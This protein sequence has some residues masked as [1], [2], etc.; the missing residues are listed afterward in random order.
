MDQIKVGKI[1]VLI[2]MQSLSGK[3]RCTAFLT[4]STQDTV[5]IFSASFVIKKHEVVI[6]YMA[7]YNKSWFSEKGCKVWIKIQ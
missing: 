2:L 6:N 1:I 4:N 3:S 5:P 7:R